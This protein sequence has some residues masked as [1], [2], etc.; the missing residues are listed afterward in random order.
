MPSYE[1]AIEFKS[2]HV[3]RPMVQQIAGAAIHTRADVSE[4]IIRAPSAAKTAHNAVADYNDDDAPLKNRTG[5]P[6]RVTL[7]LGPGRE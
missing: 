4:V 1:I 3:T 2:G 6:V 7:A 5:D